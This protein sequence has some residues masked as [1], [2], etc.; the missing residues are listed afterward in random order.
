MKY[1][2]C[3]RYCPIL[4]LMY[5]EEKRRSRRVASILF[6][7]LKWLLVETGC[8]MHSI[9]LH[10]LSLVPFIGGSTIMKYAKDTCMLSKKMCSISYWGKDHLRL[11]KAYMISGWVRNMQIN[12]QTN[13]M[14][15]KMVFVLVHALEEKSNQLKLML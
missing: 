11:T 12:K 5:M 2:F 13:N 14:S 15:S 1:L 7:H 6:V 9:S 10:S 4:C 3:F 8:C